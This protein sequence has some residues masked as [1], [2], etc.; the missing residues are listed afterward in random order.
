MGHHELKPFA[1]E[2]SRRDFLLRLL[3]GYMGLA[4]STTLAGCHLGERQSAETFIARARDYSVDLASIIKAGLRELAISEQEIKGKRI[5]LK[6]NLV[7]PHRG[8]VTLTRIP[9]SFEGQ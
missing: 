3:K 1:S 7:E 6:P 9:L 2:V 5:L 4:F 8:A